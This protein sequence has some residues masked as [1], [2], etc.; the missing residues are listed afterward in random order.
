MMGQS[1]IYL[2]WKEL[3]DFHAYVMGAE[4]SDILEREERANT[5]LSASEWKQRGEEAC[6]NGNTCQR[7]A[8]WEE[9]SVR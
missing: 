5:P 7:L 3:S 8:T 2:H 9:I 4:S 6:L 1:I